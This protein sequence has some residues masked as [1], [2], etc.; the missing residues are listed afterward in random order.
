M[1]N[2]I[3]Y[4]NFSDSTANDQCTRTQDDLT[5]T[6]DETFSASLDFRFMGTDG[7]AHVFHQFDIPSQTL[8]CGMRQ[9]GAI[10]RARR[11]VAGFR[12]LDSASS[13]GGTTRRTTW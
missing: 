9:P 3:C 1:A 5:C 8:A 11:S 7:Q 6:W 10:L 4:T 2:P 13:P 12:F